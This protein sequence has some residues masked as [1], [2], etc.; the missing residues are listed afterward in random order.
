MPLAHGPAMSPRALH[1]VVA[2]ALLLLPACESPTF[3]QDAP[4][5][6]TIYDGTAFSGVSLTL[7]RDFP[8]LED[9]H[10]PCATGGS[11]QGDSGTLTWNDCIRSIRVSPGWVATLY[12]DDDYRGGSLRITEDIP[13]L[14]RV[15]GTCGEGL[16][17]CI[18]SIRVSR[19]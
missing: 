9:I 16:D 17:R 18:S 6:V 11:D 14:R 2:A 8:D 5:G 13:D 10:G 4:E 1:C 7:D 19:R 12:G 3:V 15:T